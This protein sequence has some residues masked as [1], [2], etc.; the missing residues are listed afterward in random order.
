METAV[1]HLDKWSCTT[2]TK[3]TVE[4][5]ALSAVLASVNVYARAGEQRYKGGN[6]TGDRWQP[7]Y[8]ESYQEVCHNFSKQEHAEIRKTKTKKHKRQP[9]QQLPPDVISHGGM[10]AAP[11][12]Q[13]D[14]EEKSKRNGSLLGFHIRSCGTQRQQP[15]LTDILG[16]APLSATLFRTGGS[17]RNELWS[18]ARA[19]SSP[20]GR[21]GQ[22]TRSPGGAPST[23]TTIRSGQGRS[24]ISEN[25]V[26][27]R[28]ACTRTGAAG[29]ASRFPAAKQR[30]G[31]T[32]YKRLPPCSI[33]ALMEA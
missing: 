19:Y 8:R 33:A 16:P 25:S 3:L 21:G 1:R 12:S 14:E 13:E 20:C 26:K 10:L 11:R 6:G 27:R 29:V 31:G 22:G 28:I 4:S 15:T 17:V 23:P 5:P 2:F 32:P 7:R 30:R 24:S 9:K 18:L